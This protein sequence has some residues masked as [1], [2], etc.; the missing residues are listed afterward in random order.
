MFE[1]I[2]KPEFNISKKENCLKNQALNFSDS[3]LL[4]AITTRSFC[5]NYSAAYRITSIFHTQNINAGIQ[6]A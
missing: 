5:Q 6:K 4:I 1:P 2:R 3:F